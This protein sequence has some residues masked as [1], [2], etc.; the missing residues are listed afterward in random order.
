MSVHN[1]LAFLSIESINHIAEQ[2]TKY[3]QHFESPDQDSENEF[4]H[5][6]MILQSLTQIGFTSNKIHESLI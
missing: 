6:V 5:L 3:I 2:I 4:H 1:E